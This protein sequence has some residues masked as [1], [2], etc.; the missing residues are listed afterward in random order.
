[1]YLCICV[2]MYLCIY[3]YMHLVITYA[4][5]CSQ[6]TVSHR[7]HQAWAAWSR[8]RPALTSASAPALPLRLRLWRACIPPIALYA[9]DC[10]PLTSNHITR[11]QQVL[12]T[13]LRAL[14]RS[15]AHM[16]FETTVGLHRRL[17]VPMVHET[18]SQAAERQ[19]ARQAQLS[20][21]ETYLASPDWLECI[22]QALQQSRACVL[23]ETSTRKSPTRHC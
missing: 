6:L 14:A 7:L 3:V 8:L 1:M 22:S 13:Q 11:V 16:T 19:S 5:D 15:Q 4:E 12:T 21:E 18:L 23:S 9:L 17:K 10:L 20:N 2:F